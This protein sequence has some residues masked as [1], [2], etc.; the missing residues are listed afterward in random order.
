MDSILETIHSYLP[1]HRGK[2][3]FQFI[4]QQTQFFIPSFSQFK[5]RPEDKHFSENRC[6]FSHYQ[7]RSA[8]EVS[9]LPSC[10]ILMDAVSK[11]VCQGLN[12][13]VYSGIVYHHIR[14]NI[15]CYGV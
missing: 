6:C 10:Q 12:I 1:E 14:V 7:W 9:L 5:L 8:V 13:T 4:A 3:L 11:F 2:D 15:R